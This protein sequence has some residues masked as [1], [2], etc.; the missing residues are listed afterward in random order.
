MERYKK[1][2]I[3]NSF[4]NLIELGI[5]NSVGVGIYVLLGYVTKEIVGPPAFISIFL[6]GFAAILTG[7][8]IFFLLNRKKI[9]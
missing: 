8:I 4:I 2:K 9:N 1:S 7:I 3:L 6:S 5:G